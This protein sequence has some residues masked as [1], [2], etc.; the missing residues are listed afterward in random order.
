MSADL[1]KHLAVVAEAHGGDLERACQH[2][3]ACCYARVAVNG[4]PVLVRSL[5]CKHLE[6][7][8]G[9]E[10]R[11]SV[12]ADRHRVAPWCL[13]L[14][15]GIEKAIFPDPCPYVSTLEGYRGP[16]VLDEIQYRL[17]EGAIR[18][19]LRQRPCPE[20]ADPAAWHA[21]VDGAIQ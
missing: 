5:R 19:A 2:C 16:A 4:Q 8:P 6:V 12:Y 9:G 21:Y 18:D 1:R 14:Q 7:A 13:E 20:W 10:S 15:A 11:C 17:V 3:A